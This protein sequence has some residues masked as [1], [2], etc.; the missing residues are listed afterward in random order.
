MRP[1]LLDAMIE[2]GE[3]IDLTTGE[4]M[5]DDKGNPIKITEQDRQKLKAIRETLFSLEPQNRQNFLTSFKSLLDAFGD[6]GALDFL[7]FINQADDFPELKALK[8]IG[9]TSGS[10]KKF[11]QDYL[12]LWNASQ[13][14]NDSDKKAFI[15]FVKTFKQETGLDDDGYK[16]FITF[17][18]NWYQHPDTSDETDNTDNTNTSTHNKFVDFILHLFHH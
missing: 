3:L 8:L 11:A 17:V 4:V 5:K 18:L 7:N 15:N 10:L 6:E 9:S 2:K 14:G 16:A 13:K 12:K 1:D